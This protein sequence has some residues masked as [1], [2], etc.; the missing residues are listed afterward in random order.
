M[1]ASL[2]RGVL[3]AEEEA[4]QVA[5][6]EQTRAQ[7]LDASARVTAETSTRRRAVHHTPRPRLIVQASSPISGPSAETTDRYDEQAGFSMP[8]TQESWH[9]EVQKQY[10]GGIGGV[11]QGNAYMYT[12]PSFA[13]KGGDPDFVALRSLLVYD[14]ARQWDGVPHGACPK[15]GFTSEI[16]TNGWA[17][18]RRV[19][20]VS[21]PMYVTCRVLGCKYC[22][23]AGKSK[24]KWFR[25]FD[26][27]VTAHFATS[28]PFVTAAPS[29]IIS[30]VH[31][32]LTTELATLVQRHCIKGNP[33]DLAS[34]LEEFHQ[35]RFH[36]QLYEFYSW[37]V[38]TSKKRVATGQ[39]TLHDT[40]AAAASAGRVVSLVT[41]SKRATKPAGVRCAPTCSLQPLAS[42]PSLQHA[43]C[44]PTLATARF[45]IKAGRPASQPAG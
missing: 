28:Y 17:P 25:A 33:T 27:G 19:S 45:G 18:P 15:C 6:R 8:A 16:V 12:P 23:G 10:S 11:L 3:P 4:R 5:Q 42:R 29:F 37:C 13:S 26:P 43:T 30:N 35:Q 2:Q 21:E 40:T 22:Q 32:A 39:Q 14:P 7:N 9:R 20:G 38:W 34:Q 36:Q 31:A 24:C 41:A 44:A 1:L